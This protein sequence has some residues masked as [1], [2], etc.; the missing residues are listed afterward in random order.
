MLSLINFVLLAD[1]GKSAIGWSLALI[2]LALGITAVV[3]PGKRK[4][5]TGE[6]EDLKKK[7]KKK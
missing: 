6:D 1:A 4:S 7:K 3:F 5:P 2:G